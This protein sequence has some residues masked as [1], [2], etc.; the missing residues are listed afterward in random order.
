MRHGLL[1]AGMAA[2]MGLGL[3]Q[4]SRHATSAALSD[5]ARVAIDLRCQ[6]RNG[7]AASECRGLLEKLYAAG[8]LDPEKTF[9]AHCTPPETLAWGARQAPPPRLCVARYGGWQKG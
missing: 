3:V 2:C 7:R 4:V 1:A 6:G 9:R 5:E 8:A